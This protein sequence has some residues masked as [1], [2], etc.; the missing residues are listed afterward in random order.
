MKVLCV[1]NPA[2]GKSTPILSAFNSFFN[3]N[4]I[5]W[6]IFITGHDGFDCKGYDAV[7][8][9]GGDGTV[10]EYLDKVDCPVLILQ[11]GTAN[12]IAKDIG[13][14]NKIEDALKILLKKNIKAFDSFLVNG[15]KA[16]LR[17]YCGPPTRMMK[18]VQRED[19]NLLGLAA[20]LNAIIQGTKFEFTKYQIEIDGQKKEIDT[21]IFIVSNFAALGLAQIKLDQRI[22]AADGKLDLLIMNDP[23]SLSRKHWKFKKM[24][25]KTDQKALWSIDDS[26]EEFDHVTF[27]VVPKDYKL[28]LP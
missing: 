21:N 19:K 12:L 2:S 14:P 8:I 11:G 17:S 6:D 28:F 3:E 10:C 15:R 4:K 18:N 23:L 25:V 26:F 7:V 22:E 20:Y 13:I 1:I 16:Y 27:E 9:Y 24:T 5:E